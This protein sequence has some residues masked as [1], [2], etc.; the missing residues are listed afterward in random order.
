MLGTHRWRVDVAERGGRTKGSP[1]LVARR[2]AEIVS[3]RE[4]N[5]KD[6]MDVVRAPFPEHAGALDTTLGILGLVWAQVARSAKVSHLELDS[7]LY[8]GKWRTVLA[9]SFAHLRRQA[10]ARGEVA[11]ENSFASPE[12][13]LAFLELLAHAS[14]DGG[15]E[16]GSSVPAVR[17]DVRALP[18]TQEQRRL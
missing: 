11:V 3:C 16:Q 1:M 6:T 5:E 10:D 14:A 15:V 9:E 17:A 18:Q 4:M 2:L 8:L 7:P 12:Q 13:C